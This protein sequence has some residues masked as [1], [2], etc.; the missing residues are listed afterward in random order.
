MRRQPYCNTALTRQN[1]ESLQHP[2]L[3]RDLVGIESHTQRSIDDGGQIEGAITRSRD[4]MSSGGGAVTVIS[5]KLKGCLNTRECA[6]NMGREAEIV[7]SE[8]FA[9]KAQLPP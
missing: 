9:S 6:C 1:C 8:C 2:I 7:A 5:F 3:E 4:N